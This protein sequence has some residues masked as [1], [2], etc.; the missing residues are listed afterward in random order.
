MG[1]DVIIDGMIARLATAW[2]M[3]V[4]VYGVYGRRRRCQIYILPV[5]RE[6][7]LCWVRQAAPRRSA[8]F[9][10]CDSLQ[11]LYC[12][13]F[14]PL[15]SLRLSSCFQRWR[16]HPAQPLCERHAAPRHAVPRRV[17]RRQTAAME[18][19]VITRERNFV[20]NVARSIHTFY[21]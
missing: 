14:Q 19:T 20:S 6:Q 1:F 5:Q 2:S 4:T 18:F 8:S 3:R 15:S 21:Q 7:A 13:L 11:G 10:H 9:S 16:Y 12:P 17:V